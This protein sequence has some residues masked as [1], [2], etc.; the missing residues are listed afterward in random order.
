MN[1]IKNIFY[2]KIILLLILLFLLLQTQSVVRSKMDK[3][4]DKLADILNTDRENVDIF[5]VQLRRKHPPQTD[6]RFSAHSSPYYKP[7]KLNGLVLM[8]REE[9]STNS[10]CSCNNFL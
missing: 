4:R 6:I 2:T 9:V 5:S 1:E 3:L 8:H 7:V 10:V